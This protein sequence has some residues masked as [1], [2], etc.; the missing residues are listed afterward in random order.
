M[1]TYETDTLKLEHTKRIG[2]DDPY[3]KM[4]SRENGRRPC[5][6]LSRISKRL[7]FRQGKF[8]P[9]LSSFHLLSFQR[10]SS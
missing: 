6:R 10:K 7:I 3:F 4:L 5:G 2:Q 8:F 1:L 9:A